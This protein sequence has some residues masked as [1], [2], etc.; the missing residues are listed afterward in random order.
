MLP[1]VGLF[2][3]RTFS[4]GLLETRGYRL[5]CLA[6]NLLC[7]SAAPAFVIIATV[8]L[9][10]GAGSAFFA[11]VVALPVLVVRGTVRSVRAAALWGLGLGVALVLLMLFAHWLFT[12]P[13]EP[14]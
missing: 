11:I 5:R 14:G 8:L 7:A 1:P 4:D 10:G 6:E 3:T 12:H 9:G 13:I 2:V